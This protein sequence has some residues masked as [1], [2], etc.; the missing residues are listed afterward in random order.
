[1]YIT[2]VLEL[3][4]DPSYGLFIHEDLGFHFERFDGRRFVPNEEKRRNHPEDD[5]VALSLTNV[6]LV[7]I[8]WIVFFHL[9]SDRKL[10][11]QTWHLSVVASWF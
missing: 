6:L 5:A 1:M 2:D 4:P 10:I 11:L 3:Y 9:K 8:D 7:V